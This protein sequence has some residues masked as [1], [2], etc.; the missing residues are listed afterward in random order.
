[1]SYLP[2]ISALDKSLFGGIRA[3]PDKQLIML[4]NDYPGPAPTQRRFTGVSDVLCIAAQREATVNF[5]PH[6][7]LGFDVLR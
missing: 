7:T 3:H 4:M 1:M 5:T 6:V 2:G